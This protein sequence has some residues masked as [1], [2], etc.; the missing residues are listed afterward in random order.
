MAKTSDKELP[1]IAHL[2]ELRDR[3][4]RVAA[5][6]LLGF[7]VAYVFRVQLYD[8]LTMPVW[9]VL[10]KH[11]IYHLRVLD[12][13]EAIMMYLK[14]SLIA[15]LVGTSPYVLAQVWRFVAP[16]L[17]L[18][19][20]RSLFAVLIPS[21]LFFL[22]GVLFAY[23]VMIP[24]VVDFLVGYALENPTLAVELTVKSTIN[25]ELTFLMIFAIVF[26]LPLVMGF[27]SAMG[28]VTYRTYV[29][30][31]RVALVIAFIVAAL[32]TPPDVVSQT[33]M[34]GPLICL[35][36]LGVLAAYVIY[37]RKT[38][39][40]GIPVAAFVRF[41]VFLALVLGVAYAFALH[42]VLFPSA[43]VGV[44]AL[45]WTGAGGEI[46]PVATP[47]PADPRS[48]A[49]DDAVDNTTDDPAEEPAPQ[50]EG[51][52]RALR[53][54]DG[55]VNEL[56]GPTPPE[57]FVDEEP[58][59]GEDAAAI[60]GRIPCRGRCY[61]E[62]DA[63]ALLKKS[64]PGFASMARYI[65]DPLLSCEEEEIGG[66]KSGRLALVFSYRATDP[67][68]RFLLEDLVRQSLPRLAAPMQRLAR[69]LELEAEG[70]IL[71]VS[72][73]LPYTACR[74]WLQELILDPATDA[75]PE[76]P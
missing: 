43:R 17:Y 65:V 68:L 18:K 61:W 23:T 51:Y 12:V 30:H 9:R 66:E 3:L 25:F 47:P 1:L 33:M 40:E 70:N 6:L 48:N 59:R 56:E 42:P 34:A 64:A 38:G 39:E 35:Y 24:F 10:H 5:A 15:S 49:A 29:K 46:P 60:V 16:G 52:L 26:E 4:V 44:D 20:R 67:W 32:F 36:S 71:R 21:V 11:G 76:K 14:V 72:G 73:R 31:A 2:G 22:L 53:Y 75:E 28:L 13:T 69:E 19:E 37:L 27:M 54:D 55:R 41:G 7:A 62:K 57:S 50:H 63:L 8:V 58:Y 45:V 74:E